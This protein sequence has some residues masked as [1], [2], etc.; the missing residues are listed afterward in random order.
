MKS[1]NLK[2]NAFFKSLMLEHHLK[3]KNNQ[4]IIVNIYKF[5]SIENRM[6]NMNTKKSTK[7]RVCTLNWLILQE[8]ID[9]IVGNRNDSLI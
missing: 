4:F 3:S 6:S 7:F 2:R 1:K 8:L 9:V 5:W